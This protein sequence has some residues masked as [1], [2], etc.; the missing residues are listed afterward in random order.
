MNFTILVIYKAKYDGAR[1]DFV[2]E[3]TEKGVLDAIRK[4]NGCFNYDYYY[5]NEDKL[6]LVLF[7]K[8]ESQ[9]HQKIHMTQ[10]HMATAMNIKSK[11]IEKAEL[12]QIDIN[13]L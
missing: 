9:E 6:K 1:E 13:D 10:P 2:K 7:E 5:S 3:L 11:Y 8:W 4:E 12:K